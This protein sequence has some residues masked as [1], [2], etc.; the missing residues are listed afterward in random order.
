MSKT[1]MPKKRYP[2]PH[3]ITAEEAMREAEE[4]KQDLIEKAVKLIMFVLGYALAWS[5]KAGCS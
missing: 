1:A 3:E 5:M 2:H 4:F